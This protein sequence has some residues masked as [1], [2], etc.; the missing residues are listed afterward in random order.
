MTARWVRRKLVRRAQIVRHELDARIAQRI[1]TNAVTNLILDSNT[2]NGATADFIT[3]A[4]YCGG[5]GWPRMLYRGQI[6][7]QV[8]LQ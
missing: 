2:Q 4:A 7:C 8:V 3:S 5:W 1:V 6:L